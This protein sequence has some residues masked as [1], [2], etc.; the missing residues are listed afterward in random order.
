VTATVG[1]YVTAVIP[2]PNCAEAPGGLPNAVTGGYE[3]SPTLPV[4]RFAPD[5]QYGGSTASRWILELAPNNSPLSRQA[6]VWVLCAN[7]TGA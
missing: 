7:G 4:Q 1:P 5:V 3:I 2:S 6:S